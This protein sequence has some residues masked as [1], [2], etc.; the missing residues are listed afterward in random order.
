MVAKTKR[1]SKVTPK[2]AATEAVLDTGGISP[3]V[4]K[5]PFNV[6][7]CALLSLATGISVQTLREFREALFTVHPSSIY[8]HFWGRLLQAHFDEPEYNNDFAGWAIHGLDD[9]S[10]AERL[11]V[12][13]PTEFEDIEQLRTEVI[14]IVE[15][16]LD[17]S[18]LL[19]WTR[20]DSPFHFIRTQIVVLDTGVRVDDPAEMVEAIPKMSPGGIF[21]HFIDART[22]TDERAD[23][24]SAWLAGYGYE[25]V[26]LI[27]ELVMLDPYF[28]SLKE[29]R[30]KLAEIFEGYFQERRQ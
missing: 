19:A 2:P 7:D 5:R 28:S 27:R 21:Y 4:K 26:D 9:R 17:E 22:R 20:A 29:L 6:R 16:R 18:E 30:L 23:D 10:L 13:D 3:G 24:F 25:H 14:E 1:K 12:I 11:A 8:H 15:Q